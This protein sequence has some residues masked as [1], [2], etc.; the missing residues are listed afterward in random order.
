MLRIKLC[1][2]ILACLLVCTLIPKRVSSIAGVV[3]L[4]KTPQ[5]ALNLNPSLSDDGKVV[6][7]E[8]S[9]NFFAGGVNDSF[10]AIRVDVRGDP[11]VFVDVGRTRI[12]SPALSSDGS[13]VA[14][15]SRDDLVGK[16]PD[17]NWE[18]FL[19]NGS[20]LTQITRIKA[21]QN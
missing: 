3:R 14:F 8:S 6:V 10:H 9:A 21:D 19:L 13:V 20:E 5:Q 7:F 2:L 12:V 11:P 16:N 15:A 17:R 18:V 4:T 1:F